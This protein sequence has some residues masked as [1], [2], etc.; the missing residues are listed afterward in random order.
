MREL[1]PVRLFTA[2]AV[3]WSIWGPA[4][5]VAV[6][7]ALV[8]WIADLLSDRIFPKGAALVQPVW[9][10]VHSVALR[11]GNAVLGVNPGE[12]SR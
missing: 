11:C 8:A 6:P 10:F 5:A 1:H 3:Y 2:R 4:V 9:G 12:G 7:F